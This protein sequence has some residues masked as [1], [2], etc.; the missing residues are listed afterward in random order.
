MSDP[1]MD[2]AT[3]TPARPHEAA[4]LAAQLDATDV[5]IRAMLVREHGYSREMAAA[6]VAAN[7]LALDEARAY[8]CLD[9]RR[10]MNRIARP[11]LMT[12]AERDDPDAFDVTR[13]STQ[14]L[15]ASE[16][17]ARARL[18][19]TLEAAMERIAKPKGKAA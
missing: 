19:M 6:F 18:G 2:V 5:E 4:D 15:K 1:G 10:W 3:R 11:D 14:T 8:G 13:I 17:L 7:K 9:L 16:M 12:Q